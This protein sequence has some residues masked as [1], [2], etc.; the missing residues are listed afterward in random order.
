[1]QR[2]G[3]KWKVTVTLNERVKR[4]LEAATLRSS[5]K[6]SISKIIEWCVEKALKDEAKSIKEKI[7]EH[8]A[9]AAHW[10]KILKEYEEINTK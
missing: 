3:N 1:M 9:K 2:M 10:L 8:Q 7:A 5:K 6:R 4:L